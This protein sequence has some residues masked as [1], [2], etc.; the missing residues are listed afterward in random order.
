[1]KLFVGNL[2]KT[3][4]EEQ[5]KRLFSDCGTVTSAVIVYDGY[6]HRSRGFGY[7]DMPEEAEAVSAIYRLHNVY[8]MRQWLVV[9][10]EKAGAK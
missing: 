3:A 4:S 7:V 10:R 8:F 5:L 1:M 6:T 2:N 9:R